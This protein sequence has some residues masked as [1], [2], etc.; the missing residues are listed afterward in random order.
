MTSE[1]VHAALDE[2]DHP[3]VTVLLALAIN[4]IFESGMVLQVNRGPSLQRFKQL[5]H[6]STHRSFMGKRLHEAVISTDD[7]HCLLD[8]KYLPRFLVSRLLC[9][10]SI[11]GLSGDFG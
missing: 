9:T 2:T 8:E 1:K 4:H 11:A 10:G 6:Q 7:P 5:I 3:E